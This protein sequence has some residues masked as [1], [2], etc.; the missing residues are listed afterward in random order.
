MGG[1]HQRASSG[2]VYHGQ[3]HQASFWAGSLGIAPAPQGRHRPTWDELAWGSTGPGGRVLSLGMPPLSPCA[4]R[5]GLA[6]QPRQQ[7]AWWWPPGTGAQG[8]ASQKPAQPGFRA[9][10]PVRGCLSQSLRTQEPHP[11][12]RHTHLCCLQP[13]AIPKPVATVYLGEGT[14][15]CG[16]ALPREADGAAAS[17]RTTKGSCLLTA[18]LRGRLGTFSHTPW[19]SAGGGWP[20]SGPWPSLWPVPSTQVRCPLASP[21]WL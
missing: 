14:C 11:S 12:C 16:P 20:H 1:H 8:S 15:R 13:R 3:D 10:C 6:Q 2:R 9:G 17:S 5:V 4:V 21:G 18:V 19:V 7:E